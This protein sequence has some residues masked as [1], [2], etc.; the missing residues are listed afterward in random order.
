MRTLWLR[1]VV[2]VLL[3]VPGTLFANTVY[4]YTG[5][6]FN[7]W[8]GGDSC[9]SGVG[10]CRVTGTFTLSSPLAPNLVDATFT[11]LTYSFFDGV[12]TLDPANS[13]AVFHLFYTDASGNI[14]AW[15]MGAIDP[16]YYSPSEY[17]TIGGGISY[18]PESGGQDTSCSTGGIYGP[19]CAT[20]FTGPGLPG[21]WVRTETAAPEPSS[22]LLL[23][24]GLVGLLS[25]VIPGRKGGLRKIMIRLG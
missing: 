10:E 18:P 21:T 5:Q 16:T 12:N 8:F 17:L 13:T 24:T 23:S 15:N 20:Q 25:A 19:Y 1:M 2:V 22:L 14:V 4:T 6:S 9:I 3:Q 11:P 7:V